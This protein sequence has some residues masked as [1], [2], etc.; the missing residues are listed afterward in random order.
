MKVTY[1]YTLSHTHTEREKT[2]NGFIK[3]DVILCY[4]IYCICN[5]LIIFNLNL[6]FSLSLIC[7]YFFVLCNY[8]KINALTAKYTRIFFILS[9]DHDMY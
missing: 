6:I 7:D 1:T 2:R 4:S 3:I 9:H 5:V 8:L